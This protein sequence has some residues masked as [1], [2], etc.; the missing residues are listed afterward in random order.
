MEVFYLHVCLYPKCV[1]SVYKGQRQ[2]SDLLELELRTAVSCH[3]SAGN[4]T[5]NF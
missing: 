5:H 3:E 1:V 4:C 2:I